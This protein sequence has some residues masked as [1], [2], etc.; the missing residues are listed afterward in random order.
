MESRGNEITSQHTANC[1]YTT[2]GYKFIFF[3]VCTLGV[4]NKI[5]NFVDVNSKGAMNDDIP[6]EVHSVLDGYLALNH[7]RRTP[8][9]YAILKAV[10]R[11][12]H[13]FTIE[14]LDA[15]LQ[16]DNFRVSRATLY[17]TVRLFLRLRLVVRHQLLGGTRYEAAWPGR[18]H[19]KQIC[20]IC[21]K[22][23]EI[24]VPLMDEA[25]AQANL[26]RFRSDVYSLYIYGVC[27][28]CQSKLTRSRNKQIG[29]SKQR[30]I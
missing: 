13:P 14:E 8:E 10:Y 28:A 15:E 12:K 18:N 21:G 9:R 22:V 5:I 3:K 6:A 26:R 20:T 27:A 7:H 17:N 30:K 4:T 16:K 25:I 2:I 23:S 11:N 1:P 24:S 29:K 19:C